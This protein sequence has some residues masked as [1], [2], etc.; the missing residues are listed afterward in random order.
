MSAEA[1]HEAE[2]VPAST[3]KQR[4]KPAAATRQHAHPSPAGVV[5][6]RLL[7]PGDADPSFST[8]MT[9]TMYCTKQGPM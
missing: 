4:S 7:D 6:F 1:G 5:K 3:P 8:A 2:H 9:V